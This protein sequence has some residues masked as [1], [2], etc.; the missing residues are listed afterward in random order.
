MTTDDLI[1]ALKSTLIRAGTQGVMQYLVALSSFFALPIVGPLMSQL[2]TYIL[3]IAIR[4][5]ELGAYFVYTDMFTSAQ[6]KKFQ[7]AAIKNQEAQ[8]SGTN[9]E[10]K[11]SEADLINAARALIKFSH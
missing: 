4:Y 9:E 5:T 8:K 7:D 2:V 3:G 11:Q 1:E 10:K 6:G